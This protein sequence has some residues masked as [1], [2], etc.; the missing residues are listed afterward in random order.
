MRHSRSTSEISQ[1]LRLTVLSCTHQHASLRLFQFD[2]RSSVIGVENYA[3]YG[4]EG[5]H[6]EDP[7]GKL[8]VVS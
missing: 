7:L 5:Q 3:V 4:V 2:V 1:S 8:H 6:H